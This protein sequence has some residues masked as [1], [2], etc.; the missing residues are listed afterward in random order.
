VRLRAERY[1]VARARRNIDR[2]DVA[3]LVVDGTEPLS[4][5]DAQ[6]AGY[7]SDARRPLIVAVNKWDLVEGREQEAKRRSDEVRL[8]LGFAKEAPVLLVSAK[9]GQR[10]SRLLEEAARLWESGGISIPTPELNRWLR[11]TGLAATHEG[12]RGG[13]RFYYVTQTGTHPPRFLLFCN[14]PA[15]VHFSVRRRLENLLRARY[16]FGGTPL[17]LQFRARRS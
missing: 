14:D 2:C 9:T 4:S 3:I 12:R 10:V 11:E 8:R 17:Q 5:Q 15:K 16:G 6:I 1:S 13:A 7:V